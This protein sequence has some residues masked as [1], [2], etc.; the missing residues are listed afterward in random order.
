MVEVAVNGNAFS[1]ALT[2]P[3]NTLQ[4]SMS[5]ALLTNLDSDKLFFEK[6]FLEV[7]GQQ[8]HSIQVLTSYFK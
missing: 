4:S 1:P 5:P 2:P 8:R 7:L 3:V 6:Q